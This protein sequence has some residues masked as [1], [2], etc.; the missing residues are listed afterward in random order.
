LFRVHYIVEHCLSKN[1]LYV[2][3]YTFCH[4]A[5]FASMDKSDLILV[6]KDEGLV[7]EAGPCVTYAHAGSMGLGDGCGGTPANLLLTSCI[8][9][10]GTLAQ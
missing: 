9:L 2:V 3:A 8:R 1:V 5:G 7:T 10:G 6:T 4:G